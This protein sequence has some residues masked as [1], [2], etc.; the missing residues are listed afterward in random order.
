MLLTR[1]FR[2]LRGRSSAPSGVED[3][4]L[5][6]RVLC[7]ASSAEL[8]SMPYH[9]AG[10]NKELF[11]ESPVDRSR[12]VKSVLRLTDLRFASY[13]AVYYSHQLKDHSLYEGGRI[14]QG[15]RLLL[16]PG[17]FLHL[18]VPNVLALMH[19]LVEEGHDLEDIAY[20]SAAGPISYHDVL[21]GLGTEIANEGRAQRGHRTGFSRKLLDRLLFDNGFL[22]VRHLSDPAALELEVIA[23]PE[24]LHEDYRIMLGL[25]TIEAGP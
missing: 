25:K 4:R 11:S 18:K 17:G 9:Y 13:D 21:W 12:F 5:H 22:A 2:R 23:A 20:M 16:K 6:R 24:Y 1:V 15:I 14:L 8:V 19:Q 3:S 7:I 10:W